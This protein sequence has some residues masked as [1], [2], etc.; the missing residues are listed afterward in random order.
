MAGHSNEPEHIGKLIESSLQSAQARLDA[1]RRA[2]LD[3]PEEGRASSPHAGEPDYIDTTVDAPP[4][5]KPDFDATSYHDF[6]LAEF[7]W[8]LLSLKEKPADP[9]APL[10]YRDEITGHNGERVAR[11]FET[12]PSPPQEGK[13]LPVFP[14]P[15]AYSLF[16]TLL[17]LY[18]EQGCSGDKVVFGSLRT[19]CKRIGLAVTGPN[20]K[21]IQKDLD[22]LSGI[23]LRAENAYWDEKK[24]AYVHMRMWSPFTGSFYF[25][26]KPRFALQEELPFGYVNIHPQLQTVAKT[27]GF[28]AIGFPAT[29]FYQLTPLEQRL[30]VY[31]SRRFQ[32]NKYVR[33]NFEGLCDAMPIRAARADHRREILKRAV[34]GLIDKGYP[35][36]RSFEE[37]FRLRKHRGNWLAEFRRRTKPQPE[38]PIGRF[39]AEVD[40][41]D[42]ERQRVNALIAITDDPEGF[43]WWVHCTRTLGP[44][45]IGRALGTFRELYIEG[46]QP[47]REGKTKGAVM[48]GVLKGIAK[49]MGTALGRQ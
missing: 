4:P 15:T 25:T 1:R 12:F 27:R 28:F 33:R 37:D 7:P 9:H 24:R 45:V 11:V 10:V 39:Q 26:S 44:D 21:R 29:L 17:Q 18:I 40:L 20:I 30:A 42:F 8:C 49:E 31:L 13:T 3:Q 43:Y 35:C 47:I 22:V 48:T 46:G 16:Y 5:A 14:G 6:D 41:T 38:R 36:I 34:R 2:A 19:L 23:R 32:F